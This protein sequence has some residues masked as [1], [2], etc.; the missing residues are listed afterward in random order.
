MEEV[1]LKRELQGKSLLVGN[2]AERLIALANEVRAE[3]RQG[4]EFLNGT[5][6]T[7]EFAEKQFALR[8]KVIDAIVPR[9]DVHFDKS[10]TV[11]LEFGLPGLVDNGVS[12]AWSR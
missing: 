4:A 5:P 9:I 10:V 3:L 6:T 1:E 11:H 8:Q 2:R 12:P 7:P